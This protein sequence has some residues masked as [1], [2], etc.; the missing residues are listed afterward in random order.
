VVAIGAN[1]MVDK[2]QIDR[3]LSD[4]SRE[5][6][7]ELGCGPCK[8][9]VDAIGIDVLD[10]DGVDLVGD[11]FDVLK[12]FPDNS[13]DA[14]MAYHF[15]EHVADLPGLM[16]VLARIV[17]PGGSLELV[18]PHFSNPYFYSDPTHKQT[19]GLYTFCYYAESRLFKREVPSYVRNPVFSLAGV[20]LIF[21]SNRPFYFRYGVKTLMGFLFNSSAFMREFYEENLCYMFPC[22][23]VRYRIGVR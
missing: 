14:V 22:Y 12:L 1:R 18:A 16:S 17:K 9:H 8:R 13:V 11:V 2:K 15:I 19:F 3:I 21:K 10:Y 5:V 20:D 4:K 7:L 6:C 23:E